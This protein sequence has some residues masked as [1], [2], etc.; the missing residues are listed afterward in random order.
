MP[1]RRGRTSAH[2]KN[3]DITNEELKLFV[4]RCHKLKELYI[5]Q[6]KNITNIDDILKNNNLQRVFVDGKKL[7]EHIIINVPKPK[8]YN[9][10]KTI[11]KSIATQKEI[12]TLELIINN[13]ISNDSIE[14][15]DE[16]VINHL[17][18]R[19][20]VNDGKD[21]T[22]DLRIGLNRSSKIK[23]NNSIYLENISFYDINQSDK[24]YKHVKK[25][26]TSQ[27]GFSKNGNLDKF[28]SYANSVEEV[29]F[30]NQE[31]DYNTLCIISSH[32]NIK[33]IICNEIKL[34]IEGIEALEHKL[35]IN[36][37]S[38][39]D[40]DAILNLIKKE[41]IYIEVEISDDMKIISL[42][43]L[44][45]YITVLN[46][47]NMDITQKS[48]KKVLDLSEKLTQVKIQEC[49]NIHQIENIEQYEKFTQVK[50]DGKDL[51]EI[52]GVA[53]AKTMYGNTN[54]IEIDLER[55][56]GVPIKTSKYGEIRIIKIITSPDTN[57]KIKDIKII[58]IENIKEL[59]II[60]SNDD[61][62]VKIT[63]E[64]DKFLSL[65]KGLE[66]ISFCKCDLD[67]K[68]LKNLENLKELSVDSS[69]VN[70]SSIQVLPEICKEL[71]AITLA[72]CRELTDVS[73]LAQLEKLSNI[74]ISN[75]RICKG[76]DLLINYLHMNTL[77]ASNNLITNEQIR[78]IFQNNQ[79][80]E[81]DLSKNPITTITKPKEYKAN[82]EL[83]L[84]GCLLSAINVDEGIELISEGRIGIGKTN[85]YNGTKIN[86]TNNPFID[87][88][89]YLLKDELNIF[90][91]RKSVFS[92]IHMLISNLPEEQRRIEYI[93]AC[94]KYYKIPENG[95]IDKESKIYNAYIGTLAFAGIVCIEDD[96]YYYDGNEIQPIIEKDPNI[97]LQDKEKEVGILETYL[98]EE[99]KNSSNK[100]VNMYRMLENEP[101]RL[102]FDDEYVL[103]MF[104]EE[105][106]QKLQNSIF[107]TFTNRSGKEIN[108]FELP[109]Q[110]D[111][112]KK[113]PKREYDY[114]LFDKAFGG[115][116]IKLINPDGTCIFLNIPNKATHWVEEDIELRKRNITA[117]KEMISD[118]Y[119]YL[120]GA[121][122]ADIVIMEDEIQEEKLINLFTAYL[123]YKKEEIIARKTA[124]EEL[125][126]SFNLDNYTSILT[127][128]THIQQEVT[129]KLDELIKKITDSS[130]VEKVSYALKR[131]EGATQ[132]KE[133]VNKTVKKKG[134]FQ[135][136]FRRKS[137]EKEEYDNSDSEKQMQ[138]IEQIK[139]D[140]KVSAENIIDSISNCKLVQNIIMDYI[141]K[142]DRYI[143][144]AGDKLE[145]MREQENVNKEQME[146]LE[147][148]AES[149]KISR[150][151]A[152][153]TCMQFSLLSKTK[154]NLF[155]KVC[156]ATRTYTN[157]CIP[158]YI[159]IKHRFTK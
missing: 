50:L 123:P 52:P 159:A 16:L 3:S 20:M 86:C 65:F 89:K 55:Y 98:G 103:N 101:R 19:N 10:N 106:K 153:Q 80:H 96:F 142:L 68:I 67:F 112:V 122:D 57:I 62:N 81:V 84:Q 54:T 129:E 107:F 22:N 111:M 72:N 66:K 44:A 109:K 61:E 73:V 149:L 11:D 12:D 17:I 29:E 105:L 2:F 38:F 93:K 49:K 32:S 46:L 43:K 124:K 151:I 60:N 33:K 56:N 35:N 6:C 7:K 146:M 90:E 18:I 158:V 87:P 78:Y 157:P 120:E 141:G 30:T 42:E 133:E 1:I 134:F 28:L 74:D 148:K 27:T 114:S 130:E 25:V 154:A 140:L 121:T 53:T 41:S 23:V 136:L 143:Q 91:K 24:I 5:N 82:I 40:I 37:N 77:K 108:M 110:I 152:K 92:E 94:K 34:H 119:F 99:I 45:P 147:K 88:S 102:D 51:L 71:K 100:I 39:K 156:T 115:I 69:N 48:L 63:K 125:I 126:A 117:L 138:T 135:N 139:E 31:L 155:E 131:L 64:I 118:E 127:Y 76:I 116:K 132:R 97:L 145:E 26:I 113:I 104:N 4:Y 13:D 75:N 95:N 70:N 47:T 83:K 144:V 137:D 14:C 128:G 9:T 36:L 21:M 150:V 15:N 58:G 59:Q 79:L 8:G 85:Y